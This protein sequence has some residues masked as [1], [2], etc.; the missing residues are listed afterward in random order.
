M[1]YQKVLAGIGLGFVIFLLILI[2]LDMRSIRK[3]V[4]NIQTQIRYIHSSVRSIGS[5]VISIHSDVSS[6]QLGLRFR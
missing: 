3:R 6:I 5:D 2:E 1:K 4:D